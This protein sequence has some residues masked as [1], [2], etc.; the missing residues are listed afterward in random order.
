MTED[1][2]EVRATAVEFLKALGYNVLEAQSG[3]EGYQI[4]R[5]NKNIDLLFTDVVMPGSLSGSALGDKALKLYPHL[6]VLYT[7]GYPEKVKGN[8]HIL[9]PL[10]IK[11]YKLTDLAVT[12]KNLLTTADVD[13]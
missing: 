13:E 2:E 11:P 3:D 6:K 10:I 7:S 4:L 1:E 9:S 5:K 12:I 8:G